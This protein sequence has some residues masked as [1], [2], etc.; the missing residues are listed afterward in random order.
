MKIMLI[1]S[2]K[3]EHREE[4]FAEKLRKYGHE[5]KYTSGYDE[6][7]PEAESWHDYCARMMQKS[8]ATIKTVDAVLCLNFG[9]DGKPNYIGGATFCEMAYAFE[10]GK[11]IFILNDIPADATSGPNIQ[12][13]IEMF[14][15]EV[16][17]GDLTGIKET[18]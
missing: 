16:L 8:I 18:T 5:V 9:K 7:K 17:H 10:Y 2:A 6:P 4:E 13:E 11:K 12:F 14:K 3:F 15:P 1:G